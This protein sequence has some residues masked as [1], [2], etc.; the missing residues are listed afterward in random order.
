MHS[1]FHGQFSLTFAVL[2][3]SFL[4]LL[5]VA[6]AVMLAWWLAAFIPGVPGWS[7]VSLPWLV[8]IWGILNAWLGIAAGR[9][10]RG[11]R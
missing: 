1:V 10:E 5:A 4:T 8:F 6:L 7:G 9:D 11:K 2:V 3:M